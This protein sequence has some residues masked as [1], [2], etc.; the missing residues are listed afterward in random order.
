MGLIGLMDL[1][2]ITNFVF[3]WREKPPGT[4]DNLQRAG[5][6]ESSIRLGAVSS[7]KIIGKVN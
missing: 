7:L 4:E 3:G 1:P 2:K 5:E 6:S